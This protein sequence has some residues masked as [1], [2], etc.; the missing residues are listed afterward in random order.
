MFIKVEL[1]SEL[2]CITNLAFETSLTLFD[3]PNFQV[4]STDFSKPTSFGKTDPIFDLFINVTNKNDSQRGRI[5][6]TT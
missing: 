1:K 6:V 4:I 2:K 5:L 3:R